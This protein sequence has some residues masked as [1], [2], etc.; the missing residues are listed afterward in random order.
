MRLAL[1][2]CLLASGALAAQLR[3]APARHGAT[4]CAR[5]ALLR[6]RGGVRE[7]AEG[8]WD[9]LHE[10]A[11]DKLVVVDFTAV[12]CG[13]CQ[14]I[15]PTFAALADEY[16]DKAVFVKARPPAAAHCTP[17]HASAA[18]RH[19]AGI[20]HTMRRQRTA[21]ARP[22]GSTREYR[23]AGAQVA[24]SMRSLTGRMRSQVDVDELGSLA[25]E[26]GV[27][28][29]PTFL[30]YRAG[31]LIHTLRGANEDALT[32]QVAALA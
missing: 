9:E 19:L 3:S 31:E 18:Y 8:E 13:P 20:G 5:A 32:E 27:S 28:S 25:A 16:G 6:V 15:A 12:W 30:F 2:A 14:K 1:L 23:L 21:H 24:R 26:L 10:N 11:G 4:T 7:L 17:L 22:S 29:M